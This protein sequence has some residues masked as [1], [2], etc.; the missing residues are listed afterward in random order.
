MNEQTPKED[1]FKVLKLLSSSDSFTQRDLSEQIGFSLG[2]TNYLLK[3]LI[4]RGL[5]SVK[6]FSDQ[7]GKLG[8]V[9]YILTNK[10]FDERLRLTFH[11]LQ[12]KEA[13]YNQLKKEWEE[14]NGDHAIT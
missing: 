6:N 8:K 10:G 11:F 4:K 5:I 13:E 3:A 9:R 7:S 14:I 2:K 1:L 12:R